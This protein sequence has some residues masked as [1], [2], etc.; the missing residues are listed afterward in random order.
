M[1]L[2]TSFTRIA[3]PAGKCPGCRA[4]IGDW[5]TEWLSPLDQGKVFRG[6]AATDRPACGAWV[7]IP[8]Q[9]VGG[10]AP[11]GVDQVKR[12]WPQVEKWATQNPA[13]PID[14]DH[15]FNGEG[16]IYKDYFDDQANPPTA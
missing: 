16:Q 4:D 13:G 5:H 11:Q 2:A 15:Y 14:L 8:K 3:I 6:Q 7:M 10:L 12:V 1:E 9:L